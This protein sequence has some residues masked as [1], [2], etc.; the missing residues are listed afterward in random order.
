M[1]VRRKK[2]ESNLF[3]KAKMA[4]H[5]ERTYDRMFKLFRYLTFLLNRLA[6]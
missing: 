5:G 6:S 3:R 4:A 2:E 1:E